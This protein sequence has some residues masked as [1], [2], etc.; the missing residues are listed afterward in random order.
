MQ[1]RIGSVD[2]IFDKGP[3]GP[4]EVKPN[5]LG[6]PICSYFILFQGWLKPMYFDG[7]I[8]VVVFGR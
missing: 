1:V 2:A 7:E 6:S 3:T 5:S 8:K 4:H